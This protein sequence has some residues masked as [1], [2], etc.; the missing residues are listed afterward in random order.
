VLIV[1]FFL[2]A[3]LLRHFSSFRSHG[4]STWQCP[5]QRTGLHY[6]VVWWVCSRGWCLSGPETLQAIL[7]PTVFSK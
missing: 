3:L 2:P 7:H 1:A 4:F 5:E 6:I